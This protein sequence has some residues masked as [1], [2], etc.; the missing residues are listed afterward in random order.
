MRSKIFII[1]AS[2]FVMC[3]CAKKIN[4]QDQEWERQNSTE[5]LPANLKSIK[6]EVVTQTKVGQREI[7][8]SR[9][10]FE[11]IPVYSTYVKTTAVS[12]KPIRIQS[13]TV[14][15]AKTAKAPSIEINTDQ[16]YSSVIRQNVTAP[17]QFEIVAKEFVW[18]FARNKLEAA[19]LVSFFDKYTGGYEALISAHDD[20]ILIKPAGANFHQVNTSLYRIGP[21]LEDLI[22]VSL[23]EVSDGPN[24]S[25]RYVVVSTES[26]KKITSLTQEM[27]FPVDDDRFDQMQT[28]YYINQISAWIEKHL[29]L[30][31]TDKVEAVVALGNPEKL[32]SAFYFQNKIRLGKGDDKT[33]SRLTH[34]ASIVYHEYMHAVIDRVSGLGHEGEPGSL[35]EAFADFFACHILNRPLLG[36]SSYMLAP[37]KRNIGQVLK[38]DSKN[39]GLYH[40]SLIVSSLLWEIREKI[41]TEKAEKLAFEV[42]LQ[43]HPL[44]D[45]DYF[46][47]VIQLKAEEQL[48]KNEL[49][50]FKEILKSRGGLI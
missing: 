18:T 9:Q 48:S 39:G 7:K 21:K 16:H 27:I 36:E 46:L 23:V 31:M 12:K 43:L 41:G 19:I 50:L 3:S 17:R 5:S 15:V 8:I 40:D 38:F 10:V 45:F 25:S 4:L 44:S 49:A 11:N 34:D 13:H 47:K 22:D 35:N 14:E 26:D 33:Y 32:N 6:T 24:L 37:Y 1:A 2:V 42:L 28:F 20:L 30:K 29:L